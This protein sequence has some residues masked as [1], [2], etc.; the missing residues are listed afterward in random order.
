MA[1]YESS[2]KQI[3]SP[4][5]KVYAK[6]SDLNNLEALK[7]KLDDPHMTDIMKEKVP[8]EKLAEI[9]EKLDSMLFDRDS[10]SVDVQPVGVVA[11]RIIEREE[12]KCIKF[13]STNSPIGFKLWIQLLPTSDTSC[14]MKLTIDAAVNMFIKA[15]VDKPLKEGV[16]KLADML[17]MIPYA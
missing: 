17:A 7:S 1:K 16:E 5:S 14:K 2:V 15:M 9:R 13:E 3:A 4:I 10:V 12:D 11:I 6:L 8:E